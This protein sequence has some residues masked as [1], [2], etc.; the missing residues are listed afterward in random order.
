M[1][2]KLATSAL[3]LSLVSMPAFAG[4]PAAGEAA[5]KSQCQTCH[6]VINSAGEVLAGRAATKTGPNLYGI[7]GRQAGTYEGFRYG[8]SLVQAGTDGL[9][10][11][12]TEIATYLQDPTDYLRTRLDDRRARS[13]MSFKVRNQ[14]A[15]DDL[16]AYLAQFGEPAE[17]AAP[18]ATN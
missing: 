2:T 10:W 1:K 17:E 15:A 5:F 4:D 12:A 9:V 8:A 6:A 11:D 16:V 7:I 18:A 3:I 14:Q 13:Q